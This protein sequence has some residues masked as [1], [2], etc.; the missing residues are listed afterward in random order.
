MFSVLVTPFGFFLFLANSEKAKPINH[1]SLRNSNSYIMHASS[2]EEEDGRKSC[3]I[4]SD[5]PVFGIDNGVK[6]DNMEAG[7]GMFLSEDRHSERVQEQR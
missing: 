6:G 5:D 2:A 1:G 4:V 7:R 3:V